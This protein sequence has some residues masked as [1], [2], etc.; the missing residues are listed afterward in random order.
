[1]ILSTE[2]NSSTEYFIAIPVMTDVILSD[3]RLNR[4]DCYHSHIEETVKAC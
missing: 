4:E 3:F 2:Y 1:M